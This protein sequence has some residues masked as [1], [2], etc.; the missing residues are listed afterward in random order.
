MANVSIYQAKTT[1]SRLVELAEHGQE[2]TVTR[3]GRPVARIAP[4]EHHQAPR[5]L[6]TLKGK[7]WIASNFDQMDG[8]ELHD[9][10]GE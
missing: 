4:L 10:Y 6:G 9:W 1:F 2:T 3:H 8:A 5:I 7:I